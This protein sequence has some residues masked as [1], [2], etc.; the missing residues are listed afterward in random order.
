MIYSSKT[1]EKLS[2][3]I[4]EAERI[5]GF[6][7]EELMSRSRAEPLASARAIVALI[8]LIRISPLRKP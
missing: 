7:T 2:R 4:L 3:V 6:Y 1:P 8:T 5:F